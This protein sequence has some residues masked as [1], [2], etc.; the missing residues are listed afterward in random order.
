MRGIRCADPKRAAAVT[1]KA[2]G[3][4]LII[5]R[6]GPNSEVIKF[7]MPLT[8]TLAEMNEGLDILERALVAEFGEISTHEMDQAMSVA[9]E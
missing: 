8:I 9:A 1:A 4:G 7:L 6:S 2:F 3:Y 5:E